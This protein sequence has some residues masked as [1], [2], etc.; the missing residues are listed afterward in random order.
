MITNGI[1]FGDIHSYNDLDLLLSSVE[2]V[3]APINE[4]YIEKN[5]GDGSLDL[6]EAH[7]KITYGDRK[8]CKFVFTMNPA[9][10]LSD[11]AFEEKKMQVSNALNGR[12]FERIILDKD[13]EYFY[14]GRCSVNSYLSDKRIRQIVVT[15]RL[16]PWKHKVNETV[17]SFE[18]NGSEQ[19]FVLDNGRKPIV[20]VINCT[21]DIVI[22]FKNSSFGISAGTHKHLGIC[23]TEGENVLKIT[24]TGTVVFTYTEGDL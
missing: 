3:P 19:T 2:I 16:N 20:P 15:A 5:G 13:P 1:I 6:T 9:N 11:S 21:N 23:L 4:N 8:N 17:Y 22:V 14:T 24:G 7:G 12:Y 18:L 10:D